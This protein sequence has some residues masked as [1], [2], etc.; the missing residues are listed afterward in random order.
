MQHNKM[1]LIIGLILPILML[2]TLTLDKQYALQHGKEVTLSITGYDPRHLLYG[3]YLTYTINYG[4]DGICSRSIEKQEA[5]ICLDPKSFSY[6]KPEDCTTLIQGS[7]E[8]NRFIAG[9]ERFYASES[10]AKS[11]E[12][13]L[14]NGQ[15]S[16]VLSVSSNG[17]AQLRYLLV[18]GEKW[19]AQ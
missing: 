10:N 17:R 6:S 3:N 2:L 1:I 9:V 11:L 8:D 4:I 18:N 19:V 14:L 15:A 13:I 16:V 5:F 7:C 12:K